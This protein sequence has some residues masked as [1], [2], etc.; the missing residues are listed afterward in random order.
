MSITRLSGGLTPA[1]G[2]DPRTFPTIFNNA[3]DTIEAQGTAIT[4]LQSDLGNA[5]SDID[6]LEADSIPTD[7]TSPSAGEKLVFDGTNWVNLEGYVYVDTAYFTSNG[8]FSKGDYSW[9]RAIRVKCQGAGGAGSGNTGGGGGR[10]GGGGGGYAESFITNIVGLSGSETV[11]VGSGGTGGTGS[12]GSGGTSSFGSLVS[13]DGGGGAGIIGGGSGIGSGD[14]EIRG[15]SGGA[16]AAS[17]GPPYINGMGGGSHL[18]GGGRGRVSSG[19][20]DGDTGGE[21][22]GGGSGAISDS[23]A[24]NGGDGADGLVIVELFA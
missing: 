22:G 20:Q 1:D 23:T 3:A 19:N 5:E 4:G 15:S 8:T 16:G 9:L 21:Y 10:S 7:V 11:T 6:S 12:G 18:G 17:N 13:A 24:Q 2:S 14:L